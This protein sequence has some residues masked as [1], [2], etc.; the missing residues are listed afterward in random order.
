MLDSHVSNIPLYWRN[1]VQHVVTVDRFLFPILN[2]RKWHIANLRRP[3]SPRTSGYVER[4]TTHF[5][6]HRV[7]AV[8]SKFDP[9]ERVN[10]WADLKT[11]DKYCRQIPS[12]SFVDDNPFHSTI[13]NI[14]LTHSRV[15]LSK[16]QII[17]KDS[18]E[19][20]IDALEKLPSIQQIERTSKNENEIPF[21]G[22][23]QREI[24]ELKPSEQLPSIREILNGKDVDKENE[25]IVSDVLSCF[26][27]DND[28][29]QPSK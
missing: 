13:D 29:S 20:P 14:Q 25:N 23:S 9:V 2:T 21:I 18:F 5:A 26:N 24:E 7:I 8:L 11:L 6:L 12:L 19:L 28:S 15:L 17:F 16:V 4:K 3:T 22:I 10:I 27:K 1:E